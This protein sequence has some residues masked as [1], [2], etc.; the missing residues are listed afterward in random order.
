MFRNTFGWGGL[1]ESH[2]GHS[3]QQ[4]LRHAR[5]VAYPCKDS[6]GPTRAQT[7][8]L[9]PAVVWTWWLS[10]LHSTCPSFLG[11]FAGG[12]GVNALHLADVV[13]RFGP[14][15]SKYSKVPH[16]ESN[17]RS[18]RFPRR[19]VSKR[20]GAFLFWFQFRHDASRVDGN[21]D[22]ISIDF[23]PPV[24]DDVVFPTAY[25]F[26]SSVS[27]RF[28]D[29]VRDGISS[30]IHGETVPGPWCHRSTWR[31]NRNRISN[32]N[33]DVVTFPPLPQLGVVNQ[34]I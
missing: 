15:R 26:C 2:D 10:S 7:V 34:L 24:A 33:G 30:G 31:R 21:D 12:I 20:V 14:I 5:R 1:S 17:G 16:A 27:R 6:W 19:D 13:W 25:A 4:R 18:F 23:G 8:R 22:G 3:S 28:N 29:D 9:D 32:L 11:E